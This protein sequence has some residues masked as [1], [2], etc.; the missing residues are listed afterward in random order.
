MGVG[1]GGGGGGERALSVSYLVFQQAPETILLVSHSCTRTF[2]SFEVRV[3]FSFFLSFSFRFLF[4]FVLFK[5][6]F[7][8]CDGVGGW[9]GG[10]L[11]PQ[12]KIK[13]IS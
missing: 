7:S 8:A 11:V 3:S 1:W 10:H 2:S 12:A 4:V 5:F 13:L 6:S 9:V